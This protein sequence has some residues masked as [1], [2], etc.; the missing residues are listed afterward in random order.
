MAEDVAVIEQ[1]PVAPTPAEAT[2]V[3]PPAPP[4]EPLTRR[5]QLVESFKTVEKKETERGKHAV[6][7]PREQGKFAGPPVAPIAVA[8]IRPAMPK[9]Y[10]LELQKHWDALPPEFAAAVHQRELDSE[11]GIEPLKG[12]ARIADELLNE[13]KPYEELLRKEGGTPTTAIRNLLTTASIFRTG[14]QLQK[15]Q[16]VVG[17]MQSFGI[18]L[19]HIQQVLSGQAP[20]QTALDPHINQLTQ[21]VNEL[22]QNWTLAQQQ[23]A[24]RENAAYKSQ[25]DKFAADPE[26]PHFESVR[27]QMSSLMNS[28]SIDGAG[29]MTEAQ[30]LQAAYEIAVYANPTL[31]AQETARQQAKTQSQAQV[32]KSKAAGVLLSGGAPPSGPTPPVNPNDRRALIRNALARHV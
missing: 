23:Q 7:Q 2:A 24:E 31:R 9:S 16:Q 20:P 13:F 28:G 21:Q 32:Q 25:I 29:E 26:H 30:L 17:I 27:Q 22:K 3:I 14:T 10:K 18:P 19:E 8:P 1:V 5:D 12:K 11:K 15:V 4:A 6:N